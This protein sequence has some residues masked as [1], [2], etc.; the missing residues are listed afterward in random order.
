MTARPHRLVLVGLGVDAPS[1]DA[2]LLLIA[3]YADARVAYLQMGTPTLVEVLDDLAADE[4]GAHVH[5]VAAPTAGAPAPARSWLR[6]VAGDWTRRHPGSLVVTVA[7]R[8]V[9]GGEAALSSPAW[10]QVPGHGRHVLVCRGP[11]CTA[12]GSASVAEAIDDRLRERGLGDDDVLV[13]QTGCLFPCNHAPVVVV[14]PDDQW[15]G[16][17]SA[18]DA[19]ALVDSWVTEP[20]REVQRS[21]HK[22]QPLRN[23]RDSPAA[24]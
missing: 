3:E 24:P 10:E 16:P 21:I 9:T 2:D 4:P 11:R 14:H 18:E 7:D 8:P 6:R 5:L 13:T 15:W 19:R 17:V 12:R 23:D 1:Q 22:P 20:R